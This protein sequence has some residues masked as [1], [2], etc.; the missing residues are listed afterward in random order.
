LAHIVTIKANHTSSPPYEPLKTKS[1]PHTSIRNTLVL[2]VSP[3]SPRPQPSLHTVPG[4][5]LLTVLLSHNP[6]PAQVLSELEVHSSSVS[7]QAQRRYIS[8]HH[9]GQ[10]TLL[11]LRILAWLS[12]NTDIITR[13]QL[14][15]ILRVWLRI[16]RVR[17]KEAFSCSMRVPTTQL[18]STLLLNNGR[19]LVKL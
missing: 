16:S 13:T 19:R 3:S 8:P 1:F 5:A 15:L 12:R 2:P 14:V 7:T 10:T 6:S 4:Q 18:V 11:S 9:H 17:Q